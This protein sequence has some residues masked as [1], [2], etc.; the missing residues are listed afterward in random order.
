MHDYSDTLVVSK[1]DFLS[2]NNSSNSV[3][4]LSIQRI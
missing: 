1:F 3:I 4:I 2:V